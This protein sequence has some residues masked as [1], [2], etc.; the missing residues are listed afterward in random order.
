MPSPTDPAPTV[1]LTPVLLVARQQRQRRPLAQPPGRQ[2]DHAFVC[3][4][5][6]PL[7]QM[8]VP[9]G[10]RDHP[11]RR[12][13]GENAQ[14]SP[15][16]TADHPARYSPRSSVIGAARTAGLRPSWDSRLD[17]DRR[18]NHRV[19]AVV[20]HRAGD[21]RAFRQRHDRAASA[22]VRTGDRRSSHSR[23]WRRSACSGPSVGGDREKRPSP[24][25]R[26]GTASRADVTDYAR[27]SRA[28]HRYPAATTRPS[29]I[30]GDCARPQRRQ[31]GQ[32][33]G[34]T[35]PQRGAYVPYGRSP[36]AICR[37][38]GLVR[39]PV[40][41]Q[42]LSREELT[43]RQS[44][45]PGAERR[46]GGL[47]QLGDGGQRVASLDLVGRL[48]AIRERRGAARAARLP[49]PSSALRW[50]ARDGRCA[51]PSARMALVRHDRAS[52]RRTRARSW[53]GS[54]PR[55]DRPC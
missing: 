14:R 55:P 5:P 32:R 23:P 7:A 1:K 50:P 33:E 24:S 53:R 19:T 31:D 12:G 15:D 43:A 8:I 22:G 41:G 35:R 48:D 6:R 44:R 13:R 18:A 46:H 52:D 16:R 21:D 30:D 11:Q 49:P 27:V 34:R 3:G 38:C 17:D 42:A 39:R 10:R 29:T 40:D 47:E 25:V 51:P 37:G 2:G 20:H 9:W 54:W 45:I 28:G 36:D 4:S 26:T